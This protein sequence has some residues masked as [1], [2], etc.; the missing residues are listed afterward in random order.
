MELLKVL[1]FIILGP[2]VGGLVS[3]ID[4][5]ITARLQS[6]VGPPI[7]Q[8]FYDVLKLFQKE[9][10]YVR[11]SQNIYILFYLIF[12]IFT[13][14]LLF[15]G[16]D[17]LLFIFSLT[18]A[19]VFFVL[20]GFKG[21][22]PYS[23][24]G[25]Q[26]ELLQILAYEPMILLSVVGMYMVTKSFYVANIAAF[27]YPLINYL[28]GVF[29]GLVYI[30]TIKLRKSPFDL[31]TS[32]HAHQELVKGITTEYTGRSLAWI[33]LAHFYETTF[34]LGF[35]YLFFA[36]TPLIAILALIAVYFLEILIDNV[37]ARV[38]WEYMLFVSWA[39]T[40]VLGFG[41]II[42]LMFSK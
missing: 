28:P 18:L 42:V 3:G 23:Q 13:G 10:L 38:K 41:N 32:H 34:L 39:V 35:I 17:I 27:P 6:R 11:K 14:A 9:N 30:L 36:A 29:A 7:L 37:T 26:R 1:L 8:P 40:L 24:I 2:I 21:S 12:I 20:A 4:R 19:E 33:E 5:K 15:A 25:A 22:S 16:E 31:A